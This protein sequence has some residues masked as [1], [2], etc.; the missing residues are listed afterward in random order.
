[1]DDL[2]K[3]IL[4]LLEEDARATNAEI[5]RQLELS[6][7]YVRNRVKR[8]FE[9]GKVRRG[10]VVDFSVLGINT[11]ASLKLRFTASCVD[12]AIDSLAREPETG[13]VMPITGGYH[14]FVIVA[15]RSDADLREFIE[16]RVRHLDGFLGLEIS[17][18]SEATKYDS[19]FAP[20]RTLDMYH[21]RK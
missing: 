4:A 5:A 20:L 2:D 17:L 11:I 7:S 3:S 9:S 10:I 12:A 6:E 14:I 1:M 8:I 15:V 21:R 19:K 13:L 16:D 18:F